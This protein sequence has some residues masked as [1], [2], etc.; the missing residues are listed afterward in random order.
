VTTDPWAEATFAGLERAQRRRVA[1]WEPGERLGWLEEAL[2]EADERG[3][4][5]VWRAQKQREVLAAW[6][7]SGG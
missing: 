2:T 7:A 3:L 4:L 6:E 1:A 5:R